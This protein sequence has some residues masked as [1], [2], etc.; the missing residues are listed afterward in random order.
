MRKIQIFLTGSGAM[1]LRKKI[2]ISSTTI[3]SLILIILAG[4]FLTYQY[5]RISYDNIENVNIQSEVVITRTPEG[6]PLITASSKEDIFYA[7]GYIHAQDRLN[8]MEYQRALATGTVSHFITNPESELLD[9]LASI[10]GFTKEADS[11]YARLDNELKSQISKYADGV[12][13]I[14]HTR[15]LAKSDR[16]DWIPAD[17]IAILLMKEWA[18]AY[19]AN[20]EII[21]PFSESKRI[22]I[23][24]IFPSSE[25]FYFYGDDDSQYLYIIQRV[26]NLVETYIGHFN[27]GFAVH[28]PS[29]MNSS[30]NRSFTAFSQTANYNIYP[31]WYPVNLKISDQLI[32]AITYSGLPFIFSFRKESSFF[33]HFSINADSQDFI[34]FKTR[35]NNDT[36]QY[37]YRGVWKEFQPVRIPEGTDRTLNTLRWVTE[38]GSILS[39]L[40]ISQKQNDQILCINSIHPGPN[41]LKIIAT[42]PFETNSLKLRNLILTSDASLKGFLLKTDKESFKIFSGFTTTPDPGRNIISDGTRVYKPDHIKIASIKTIKSIDYIGSDLTTRKDIPVL[43]QG[44]LTTNQIKLNTLLSMLPPRK[45]YNE[46]YIQELI[47]D[48]HSGAAELFTPVF[49]QILSLTPLTSAKMTKIYFNEWDYTTRHRLQ[50]PAIFYTTLTNMFDKTFRDEF[51]NDTDTLLNYSHLLYDD[52]Y[53]ILSKNP[54]TI[55]DNTGTDQ[56]ETRETIFDQ[57]FLGSMRYL[58]RKSGPLME[59]WKWGK[60]NRN[61][62]KIPNI[63]STFYSLFFMPDDMASNGAPDSLY[64]T[65]F[66]NDFKPVSATALTGIMS[67][68]KFTF[69]MNYTYS[70]SIFSDFFYGKK[71]KVRYANSNEVSYKTVLNPL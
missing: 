7:L 38:K 60:L 5:A 59:N 63:T 68:D 55:F 32:S 37:N 65:V 27:S 31:G 56:F 44:I 16:N 62:Y 13:Q 35:K 46:K 53:Q 1:G 20:S 18:D 28:V 50:A 54:V 14:R 47:T 4:F 23:S 10:I 8:L 11:L 36:Y 69:R 70:S 57:A 29:S 67:D 43:R 71:Y 49:N 61:H 3:I 2:I 12:N 15:H 17:I 30:D 19:L 9:R 41:Y 34:L 22:T 33:T 45:I 48:T 26:K 39:D 52:F 42:A 64:C 40:I 51:G 21:F 24:K 6:V 58:N 66:S 25:K